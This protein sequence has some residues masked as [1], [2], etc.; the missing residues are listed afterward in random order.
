VTKPLSQIAAELAL[1]SKPKDAA[2]R[3]APRGADLWRPGYLLAA[4]VFVVVWAALSAPWLSGRVTIPYDAKAHFQA[5]I[6]F[7]ATALHTGQSPFWSPHTFAGSPQIADPQSL[8]FSPAALLA[9]FDAHPS[10]RVLDTYVLALLGFAGLSI[11]MFFRD[12]GWHP[13]GGVVAA[14]ALAFGASASWRVQ[15]IGQIKS[16]A[17]VWISLW[18]LSRALERRS[19]L[20]G[21]GAGLTAGVMLMEPDQV[22]LLGSYLLGAYLLN[23]WLTAP[24]RAQALKQSL[25][26]IGAA[27]LVGA[28]LVVVPLVLTML[29]VAGSNRP[30]IPFAEA[31]RGSLHPASLLTFLVG[32]LYGALDPKVDY[33]GPFS[34]S[35]DPSELTLAQNMSQLYVGALP[36]LLILTHGLTRGHAA[37]REIRFF[38]VATLLMVLYAVGRHTPLFHLLYDYLPGVQLFRRPADATFLIGGTMAILG[39]YL[40]HVLATS[41]PSSAGL[42]KRLLALGLPAGGLLAAVTVAVYQRHF[43]DAWQPIMF[44]AVWL[45]CSSLLIANLRRLSSLAPRLAIVLPAVLLAADL[46]SNNGPN[47]STALPPSGYAMLDP[48]GGNETIK[49]LKSLLQERPGSARRDRVELAGLG[50]EWPNA[51]MVHGIDHVLGYNPLRLEVITEAVGA[52]DTIAGPDQRHFTPLFPSYASRLADLLGLRYIATSVPVEEIDSKLKP[53]DLRLVTRTADAFIYENPRAFPRAM[54]ARSAVR[55]DFAE[56][57]RTGAWPDVN[58]GDVVLVE[59]DASLPV[60]S[61]MRRP[62]PLPGAARV[63]I[64]RYE[65]TR[66]ELEVSSPVDGFA[67]LNDVWHPWWGAE[68]D[69]IPAPILKANV[70]FRAVAVPAGL[71]RIVFEFQPI[72]GAFEELA[73]R[74]RPDAHAALPTSAMSFDPLDEPLALP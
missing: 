23:H 13:A 34:E 51:A 43:M 47:E 72:A 7:L 32:D 17:L 46:A 63:K 10:F 20:Y 44:A 9:Y 19:V 38:A 61:S 70:L 41:A 62:A 5:Q 69:G 68:V 2:F 49:V 65:N 30:Q 3:S 56:I 21:M 48:D 42:P 52:G 31:V 11:L 33:W 58:P 28:V 29:F 74:M 39:G 59:Q 4:A 16:F 71:H 12:R 53:G 54:F 18:L 6:Q 73:A 36:F 57:V 64:L 35:W 60:R 15:H 22:A 27:S 55:A 24:D 14:I 67:V 50:F 37:A 25:A 40:V 26:P 66:V 45:A 1:R 8:I